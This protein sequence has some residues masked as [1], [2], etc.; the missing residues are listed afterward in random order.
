MHQAGTEEEEKVAATAAETLVSIFTNNSAWITDSRCS[1]NQTD[2][3]EASDEPQVSLDSFEEGVMNLEQMRDDGDSIPV[4]APDKDG[5]SCG[6]K[7][8]R[9]RGMRDFQREILPGL[10]SLARHEICDDL[11]A[12]GYELRKT[13][14]RNP[15]DK[16]A[17]STRSRLP[18]RCSNAWT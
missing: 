9:G 2:D 15:G 7:L 18:R 13:R 12:I 16:Y 1:N 11:H 14:R 6:I 8:K 3:R 17:M 5:P 10:V 4:R